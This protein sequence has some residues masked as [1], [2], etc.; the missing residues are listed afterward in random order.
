MMMMDILHG[1]SKIKPSKD[2]V[3]QSGAPSPALLAGK[4][5]W[6]VGKP[7]LPAVI[8]HH[9]LPTPGL[10]SG[11]FIGLLRR[12][13]VSTVNLSCVTRYRDLT[14]QKASKQSASIPLVVFN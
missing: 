9:T 13:R 7:G 11:P 10:D 12:W 14:Q 3:Q 2:K 6:E 4:P 1:E 8:I 5:Q